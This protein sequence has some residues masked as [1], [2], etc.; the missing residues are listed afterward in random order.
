MENEALKREEKEKRYKVFKIQRYNKEL[1]KNEKNAVKNSL[2]V[3]SFILFSLLSVIGIIELENMNLEDYSTELFGYLVFTILNFGSVH[4]LVCYLKR[5]ITNMSNVA[6]YRKSIDD[7]NMELNIDKN[8]EKDFMLME[9][10]RAI[11][12]KREKGF[13]SNIQNGSNTFMEQDNGIVSTEEGKQK[14]SLE[15]EPFQKTYH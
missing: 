3:S 12:E 8:V 6:I 13:A 14:V 7:I 11:R 10:V 1:N 2:L 9:Q 15:K 4:G 5:L